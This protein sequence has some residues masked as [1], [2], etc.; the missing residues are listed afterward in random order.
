MLLKNREQPVRFLVFYLLRLG[1][2]SACIIVPGI[3]D[4][5]THTCDRVGLDGKLKSCGFF[6]CN[7]KSCEFYTLCEC[8]QRESDVIVVEQYYHRVS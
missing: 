6:F 2:I 8:K 7:L 3:K 5:D 1:F 4:I